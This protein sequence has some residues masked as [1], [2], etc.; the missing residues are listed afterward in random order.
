MLEAARIFERVL[1]ESPDQAKIWLN[2]AH[3]RRALGERPAALAAYEGALRANPQERGAY[4]ELIDYYL[5][6]GDEIG[7][8]GILERAAT[9][10]PRDAKRLRHV[11]GLAR[12]RYRKERS[13]EG[14]TDGADR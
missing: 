10:L 4:L 1:Q 12:D 6:V 8:E 5:E 13:A 9:H 7:A 14:Q 2:L 3:A 11:F